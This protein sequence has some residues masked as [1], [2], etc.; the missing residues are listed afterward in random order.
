MKILILNGSPKGKY[1]ITLQT[2]RYLEK[3]YP[4]HSF[5]VLNVG[6]MTKRLEKD[7]TPA[8]EAIERADVLLFSYPVYTFIAPCQLHKFIELLK[9]EDM[10][11][12][13]KYATQI[14]T[15]KH[16]YD[17][18]AHR[19]VQDNCADLGLKYIRGLSADMDDLLTDKGQKEARDFFDFLCWSVENDRFEN[20]SVRPT[21]YAKKPVSV[22]ESTEEKTGDVVILTDLREDNTQLAAMI[23]RFQ[24]KFP[25]KT[26][27][28]N[29]REYPFNGG[30]LGCFSCAVSGK[31]VHK[32]GFDE[33]LR[34]EI[35]TAESIVYAFTIQDHSMGALFKMY[36][37][38][39]FCNGHRTV[40][41]GM[42]VGYL[43]SGDLRREF[44]LQTI[45]E[46]RAQV[47]T[48]FLA[49]VATDESDPDGEI[50]RLAQTLS[51][52]LEHKYVP[53]QNFYGIGGMKIFRDL[54][55]LMQGMMR[56][57][58]K[59]Y[60]SHGQYDFPQKKRGMMLK[61]YLVGSLLANEKIKAK[62]GNKMNEGM[63]MPYEKLFKE[64][65]KK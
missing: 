63:L 24:A 3:V 59:F 35:Q 52:A 1:S 27:I 15:S 62:M 38:R 60:K 7:F 50:D 11:L 48:N 9:K 40:T 4:G 10:D 53:P 54:I 28:I 51:Y 46:A 44:N 22:V 47:G 21:T 29:L 20:P 2:T 43:I 13:A 36:D 55:W 42:P 34:N 8:R 14:T 6:Q 17:V 49:G 18:T 64:M 23:A 5:E 33:Y 37:D 19:Y 30:C 61:M 58:H 12:S 26:R 31:C 25:K 41:I 32:D 57:D 56:A 16:F 39:N 65:D 45:I